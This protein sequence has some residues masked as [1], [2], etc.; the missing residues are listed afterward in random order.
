MTVI[1]RPEQPEDAA[2]IADVV[3]R[4]FAGTDVTTGNE[5]VLVSRLR[6]DPE[7]WLGRFGFVA[8]KDG[9]IIGYVLG[10]RIQVGGSPAVALAPLAVLP[11][12]QRSGVGTQLVRRLIGE[13]RSA[14]ETLIVVLG[15]PEYYGRFGFRAADDVGILGPFHG[16]S[17][18]A[19]PLASDAPVGRAVYPAAFAGV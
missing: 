9:E 3:T 4:S 11:E 8:V 6:S 1:L 10:S 14:G 2:A 5:A 17:F 13:A 15:Y 7:S 18:Q 16:P 19:L 12:Y